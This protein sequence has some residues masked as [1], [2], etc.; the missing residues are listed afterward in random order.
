MDL[1]Q[2]LTVVS[3]HFVTFGTTFRV[4]VKVGHLSIPPT[5]NVAPKNEMLDLGIL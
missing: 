3:R 1:T 4:R 2:S 5:M